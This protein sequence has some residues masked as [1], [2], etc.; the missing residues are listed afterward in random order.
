MGRSGTVLGIIGII[1]AAGAIGFTFIV[2]N[3]QNTTNDLTRTCV[4]GVW[5]TLS[6]NLDFAP[7]NMQNNWLLEFG[8]NTLNNTDYISVSNINTRITLLK[9]GW[10]RI[11]LSVLMV[12]INPS[13][14]YRVR[15][16]K[17]GVIESFLDF[18][19]TSAAI[20]SIYHSID[21]SAFVYS[22]GTNYIEINGYSTD[23]FSVP[24][25]N[26]YNQLTIE[27]LTI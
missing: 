3:S 13:N 10:Y 20:D 15:I 26:L 2:W 25:N 12:G 24:S 17:D 19:E 11:H 6:D 8:D 7:Y 22:N 21:S 27:F 4:V 23:D 14:V 1:L 5:E 18:Y 16:L 9:S